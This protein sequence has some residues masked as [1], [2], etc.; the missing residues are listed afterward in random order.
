[1]SNLLKDYSYDFPED[2]IALY[3]AGR[4]SA[5]RLMTLDRSL[6]SASHRRFE[7]IADLLRAG[8]LLVVNDSKVFPC[9]LVTK[10]KTGGRQEIL[11]L[12]KSSAPS[13]TLSSRGEKGDDAA[14][15]QI[16]MSGGA[17]GRGSQHKL[18]FEHAEVWRAL[19]N[20]GAKVKAGDVFDFDGLRVTVL[21]EGAGERRVLLKFNGDLM[22]RL[23]HSADMPLPP[24]IRRPNEAVDRERYQTVYAEKTGSAAAPTAG[25]HFTSELLGAIRNKGVGVESVT[26]HVGPGTFLPVRVED[27]SKHEMHTESFSI[28]AEVCDA[29]NRVKKNGGRV[30]AVGT[31]AARVLETAGAGG[32]PLAPRTG[33]TDIFIRPPHEFK[34]VDALL[35]NFHQPESTLLMLVCAFAGRE[36]VLD[37][38]KQAVR[39]KY[40]LFSYGDAMLIF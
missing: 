23:A 28:G 7:D 8:D 31:T 2:L 29:V 11:L 1:M 39:E 3:P 19:L 24:Y 13:P 25:L 16:P 9:R 17:P 30:I 14:E 33:E 15:I 38:Y 35:T 10:R 40:R 18:H 12:Q 32:L 26:L 5:S 20:A 34:V 4:R 36:F 21:N 6:R 37:A 22:E 27:V